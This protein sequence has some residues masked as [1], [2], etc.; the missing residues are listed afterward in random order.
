[1]KKKACPVGGIHSDHQE[2]TMGEID[3]VHHTKDDGQPK[4]NQG[5]KKPHQNPLKYSV[6]KDHSVPNPKF[7]YRNPKQIQ[8][9]KSQKQ[10]S[11]EFCVLVILICFKFRISCFE[12]IGQESRVPNSRPIDRNVPRP[13]KAG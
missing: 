10:M 4:G 7:E 8:M 2:F 3:D 11:F 9:I 12:F 1:V 13:T 5:E 6:N